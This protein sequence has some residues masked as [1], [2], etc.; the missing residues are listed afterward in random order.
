MNTEASTAQGLGGLP[1]PRLT[2]ESQR[3]LDMAS[4]DSLILSLTTAATTQFGRTLY[5]SA[6]RGPFSVMSFPHHRPRQPSRCAEYATGSATI[7]GSIQ[8]VLPLD[9]ENQFLFSHYVSVVASKMMPFDDSR[10]P[11]KSRYPSMALDDESLACKAIRYA[12]LSQAAAHLQHMGHFPEQM[13]VLA[14]SHYSKALTALAAY[15]GDRGK[16][17]FVPLLASILSL[18][19]AEVSGPSDPE[20]K[21]SSPERENRHTK[22]AP[23]DGDN[24]SRVPGI[25]PSGHCHRSHGSLLKQLG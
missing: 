7:P 22:A 9:Q 3:I 10:N 11:W 24:I 20:R 14:M 6:T 2:W 12:I 21:V 25:W 1:D 8:P 13:K 5:Q 17:D 19:M 4:V 16:Y 15:L 23:P 18:I